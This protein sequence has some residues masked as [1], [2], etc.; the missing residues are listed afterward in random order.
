MGE[1]RAK[2][3]RALRL[4]RV[5]DVRKKK[6][7]RKRNISPDWKN[8]ACRLECCAC[9]GGIVIQRCTARAVR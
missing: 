3:S 7:R 5:V 6:R 4:S 1:N 8:R 9:L 2:S